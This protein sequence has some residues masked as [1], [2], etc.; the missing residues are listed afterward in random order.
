MAALKTIAREYA[1]EIR[2][3]IAW[4]VAWKTGRSWQAEAF[5]LDCD[6]DMFKQ[7]DMDQIRAILEQDSNAVMVNGYYCGHFGEDMTVAE[8][9]A[10]ICWHYENGTNLL[11][12]S[13]AFPP[14]SMERPEWLPADTPWYRRA[15]SAE[16]SFPAYD[17]YM[18]VGD[19]K[20]MCELMVSETKFQ[21]EIRAGPGN[22]L[23]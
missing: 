6:T 10:G 1:D 9:A 16:P 21:K 8:L 18:S 5:W 20:H 13:D 23:G 7:E 4:V 11:L 15:T 12:D 2:D 14:K 22:S 17:G 3:G 19:Y